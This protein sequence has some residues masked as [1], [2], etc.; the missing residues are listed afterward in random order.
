MQDVCDNREFESSHRRDNRDIIFRVF[1]DNA[2]MNGPT[3]FQIWLANKLE[4]R[5]SK[6]ALAA[7]LGIRQDGITRLLNWEDGKERKVLDAKT[8][9]RIRDYFDED[10]PGFSRAQ[11]RV[12]IVG[13]IDGK[14]DQVHLYRD[15]DVLKDAPVPADATSAT[16]ALE[17]QGDSIGGVA[18]NGDL[19]YFDET[20]QTPSAEL[21]GRLCIVRLQ[22]GQIILRKPSE[23]NGVWVLYSSGNA[24]PIITNSIVS[25]AKV[26]WIKLK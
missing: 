14:E 15:S 20:D 26:S 4:A 17:M 10:P 11:A 13:Y 9:V 2:P 21:Q 16:M 7:Y 8:L 22:N 6:K 12:L 24:E 18:S 3:P 23:A 1:R 5:G 19:V 25:A